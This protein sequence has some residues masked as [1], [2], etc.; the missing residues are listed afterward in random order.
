MF[1]KLFQRNQAQVLVTLEAGDDN[2]PAIRI[3]FQPEGCHMSS[4]VMEL[5]EDSDEYWAK[6]EKA[7]EETTEENAFAMAIDSCEKLGLKL[8]GI[9]G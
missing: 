6:A 3:S 2:K 1:A 8:G 5:N 7:L 9:D 4:I